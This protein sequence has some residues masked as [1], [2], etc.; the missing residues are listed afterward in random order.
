[1]RTVITII[2]A[3]ILSACAPSAESIQQALAGTQSAW[4]PIPTQTAYATYTAPP[5]AFITVIVTQTFTPAPLYTPTVTDTP[6]PTRD[7]L[8]DSRSDGFYLIGKDIAPGV[9]QSNGTTGNC[10]WAVTTATGDILDNHFGQ[11]GGTAYLPP[12]GFQVE[13]NGCGIWQF[14]SP[15]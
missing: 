5:T 1:M 13:F 6:R 12:D 11:P 7:P 9:W 8:R 10:Y 14:L 15:P 3:L 2:I 4:T